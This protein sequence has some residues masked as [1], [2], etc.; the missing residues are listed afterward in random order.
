MLVLLTIGFLTAS[1]TA[2]AA[3]PAV[4]PL[5]MAHYMPWYQYPPLNN[6]FNHWTQNPK[7]FDL[8]RKPDG[9]VNI[10]S[11]FYPLT[12]PYDSSDD[13]VLEYQAA[14][15]K[16]A[17]IDGVIFDWYGTSGA[18]DYGPIN[19][20]TVKAVSVFK[21]AELKFAIC[22]EDQTASN[23]IK[24][25]GLDP[26]QAVSEAKKDFDWLQQNFFNDQYYL[27]HNGRPVVLCFGPQYFEEKNQWNTIF[28]S[29]KPKPLFVTENG[30]ASW[31]DAVF[32]WAWPNPDGSGVL[33][34]NWTENGFYAKH[35]DKNYLIASAYSM[36]DDGIIVE[37]DGYS[38]K[39]RLIDYDGGKTL[40]WTLDMARKNNP[41]VIQLVTWNDYGEGNIFEP[42]IEYGYRDII[43][44]KNF[45]ENSLSIDLKFTDIDLSAPIELYRI[46]GD[47]AADTAL[48]NKVKEIYAA[49]FTG[50][51][52][53]FDIKIAEADIHYDGSVKPVYEP[54]RENVGGSGG[55]C[56]TGAFDMVVLAIAVVFISAKR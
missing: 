27:K 49:I 34:K 32:S 33:E 24:Y 4:K 30:E 12:G 6:I 14:L 22:Y 18:L 28:T 56:A 10:A 52:S 45:I 55:G 3:R 9:K 47:P 54:E 38:K 5:I 11:Y 8:S 17:G 42:T 37:T 19:K 51:K 39:R 41:Q 48:K 23:R 40:E 7:M 43:V 31:E 44:V 20:A 46:A 35:T 13:A 53:T 26:S 15:F 36:F 16:I 50:D 29:V 25:A 1:D 21:K 2:F